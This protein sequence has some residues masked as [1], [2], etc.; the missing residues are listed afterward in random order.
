MLNLRKL[1]INK[2][3][4]LY[5]LYFGFFAWFC[6]TGPLNPIANYDMLPY[7][8]SVL[9]YTDH[10]TELRKNS[11]VEVKKYVSAEQYNNFI[12]G[13]DYVET[14]AKDD[15]AFI[16][17][18][19]GYRVKPLY[20]LL[21]GILGKLVGNIALASV[22]ISSAGFFVIGLALYLLRPK[23]LIEIFW[24]LLIPLT[25]YFGQPSW[26]LLTKA[27]SPDSLA[28]GLVL[29][30]FWAFLRK[31]QSWYPIILMSL[32][33]LARP[34]SVVTIIC[35]SPILIKMYRDGILKTRW[36][37]G[38]AAGPIA[39]YLFIKLLFPSFGIRELIVFAWMGPYPYLSSVDTSLFA[40][41]YPSMLYYD[42]ASLTRLPRFVL[43]F[44]INIAAI[45]FC[46]DLYAKIILIAALANIVIKIFLFPNF[47]G[48]FGERFFFTS[49]FL[50]LFSIVNR[51]Q[52]QKPILLGKV[53]RTHTVTG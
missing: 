16:E 5:F 50:I 36:I 37:I 9:S 8:G 26:T 34:D 27:S 11:L 2:F 30:S 1:S 24:L 29:M 45:Y 49:Y 15:K 7:V 3:A 51:I 6:I 46:K 31:P 32:A 42:I 52:F 4:F 19:P 20:I 21:T 39:T 13:S 33:I 22:V 12:V 35:L 43:F 38:L 18:L 41:I 48:G 23:G 47:D 40:D 44:A 28:A 53:C 25:L 17:Q 10:K 14:V